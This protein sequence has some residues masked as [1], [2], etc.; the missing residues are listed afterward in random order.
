MSGT[1]RAGAIADFLAEAGWRGG[2]P[3]PMIG[4]ASF[5][6]Y[7]RVAAGHRRA[8]LM[9][10]PP[11]ESVGSYVA[12]AELLR[13][14]GLST[15]E[16]YAADRER[17]LALI[18]DFGDASYAR[19]LAAGADETALYTVA[20]DVLIALHSAVA[21][22]GLPDGLPAYDEAR[23]LAEATLL[24]DWYAPAALGRPLPHAVRGDFMER[25]RAVLPMTEATAPTLVLRDYHVD[26]LMLLAG[27]A[28][29]ATCGLLD[30]QDAMRGQPSYDL[31]SLLEDA[32]RDV[33]PAL[34]T[35]M[36]ERYLAG[37]P[38]LD[39]AGFLRSATLLAAQRHAKVIGLFVRL[40]RR[41]GKPAY[42]VHLPRVWRL[43]ED[44][45][46]REPA[47]APIAEWVDRHLPPAA[48]D[49]IVIGRT[50]A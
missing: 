19:L 23:L 41:D 47:L 49:G 1:A 42:L 39:R 35:A 18:E 2:A 26:N 3:V 17:G 30:F 31:A 10:A 11:P 40:W 24:V 5:R 16:I 22:R 25:W 37:F 32:R 45:L 15:P 33:P 34:R 28:G 27:R 8:V 46:R 38:G 7:F 12:I 6:R 36:T 43:F 48:R 20:V 4:D 9:D 44:A 13:G 21:R 50:A 14:L 29:T